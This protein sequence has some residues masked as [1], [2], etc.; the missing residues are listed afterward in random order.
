VWTSIVGFFTLL[1]GASGVF[2]EMKNAFDTMWKSEKPASGLTVMLR[3]RLTAI[4]LVLGFGFLAI[5]SLQ[6]ERRESGGGAGTW[7]ASPRA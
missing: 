3:A 2:V 6:A 4:G 5:V 7:P 1:L